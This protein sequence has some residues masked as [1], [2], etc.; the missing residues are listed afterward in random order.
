[1]IDKKYYFKRLKG[2][3][4]LQWYYVESI[5]QLRYLGSRESKYTDSKDMFIKNLRENYNIN[6]I[7]MDA[8]KYPRPFWADQE[9][10]RR[11]G[12]I[13]YF[14]GDGGRLIVELRRPNKLFIVNSWWWEKPSFKINM[15][16]NRH[17][18]TRK[19]AEDFYKIIMRRF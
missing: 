6:P 9:I 17:F 13:K 8:E 19:E 7:I 18:K 1:M 11:P 10:K 2:V 4:G 14:E 16:E 15:V 12:H 3:D 5:S